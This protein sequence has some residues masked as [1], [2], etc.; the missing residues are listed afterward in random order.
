MSWIFQPLLPCAQ[1][2]AGAPLNNYTLTADTISFAHTGVAAGLRRGL[3]VVCTSQT[4][5]QSG[6]DAALR[7]GQT[8]L[9]T[10]LAYTVSTF[11]AAAR[12]GRKATAVQV[13][14]THTGQAI[15]ARAARRMA[16]A[17]GNVYLTHYPANL[18]L[19]KRLFAVQ[20]TYSE[21]GWASAVRKA[22]KLTATQQ[23]AA[24]TVNA[25]TF[26]R[27]RRLFA[28]HATFSTTGNAALLVASHAPMTAAAVAF[29]WGEPQTGQGAYTPPSGNAANASWYGSTAYTP[30]AGNAANASFMSGGQ[31][32]L[33]LVGR[34][35]TAETDQ[36][37]LS[38]L[39]A[40]LNAGA[41][42]IYAEVCAFSSAGYSAALKASRTNQEGAGTLTVTPFQASIVASRRM[43]AATV[44]IGFVGFQSSILTGRK[45]PASVQSFQLSGIA[46][47]T[48]RQ[49]PM[50]T[51]KTTFSATGID[52]SARAA[53]RVAGSVAGFSLTG[54]DIAY[55]R[56]KYLGAA[57]GNYVL[58]GINAANSRSYRIACQ[59]R[60]YTEATVIAGTR[61]G[62]RLIATPA[63]YLLDHSPAGVLS[64]R[65]IAG[66]VIS[67]VYTG[68]VGYIRVGQAFNAT[69]AHYDVLGYGA[70]LNLVKRLRAEVAQI[71]I[72]AN[73]AVLDR[74][75]SIGGRSASLLYAVAALNGLDANHD[76]VITE[77]SRES[78]LIEQS[79][80]EDAGIVTIET[81]GMIPNGYTP[82]VWIEGLARIHGL[83]DPTDFSVL[84][85]TDGS[86]SQQITSTDTT[87]TVRRVA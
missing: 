79:I 57:V 28:D 26:S 80:S 27:G 10:T 87:R 50:P 15:G 22:S 72:A 17:L 21:T 58:T 23:S 46:A 76:L 78:G 73:D 77:T 11:A 74:V 67:I 19:V 34:L 81:I 70:S 25:A 3:N 84:G 20:A 64:G 6:I 35:V 56:G 65:R 32:T 8:M 63:A 60:A 85:T 83:I 66:G 44:S 48:L 12:T 68:N 7:R 59:S 45:V 38:G 86:L 54:Y 40:E 39:H 24:L 4:Y 18:A 49:F 2:Q 36:I 53:R 31:G 41:Y 9:A 16:A 42:T 33:L 30:P 61:H 13:A 1:Q 55:R 52:A 51:T 71:D 14:F 37:D 75:L 82:E 29:S 62:R 43:S 5:T 69:Y 47:F